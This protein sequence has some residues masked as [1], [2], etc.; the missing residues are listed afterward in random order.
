MQRAIWLQIDARPLRARERPLVLRA[1]LEALARPADIERDARLAV[2]AGVP[3]LQKPAEEPLLQSHP[4][5]A[6]EVREM[7][8]AVHFEPFL[9]RP[10]REEALIVAARMQPLSAPVRR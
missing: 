3:V 2:P 1:Q 10:C 4:V 9:F 6:I 8:F 7:R 5:V